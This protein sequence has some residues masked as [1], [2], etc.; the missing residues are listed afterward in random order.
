M[1]IKVGGGDI[2][3]QWEFA[4]DSWKRGFAEQCYPDRSVCR[5]YRNHHRKRD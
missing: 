2:N 1:E 5:Y 4:Q 3:K